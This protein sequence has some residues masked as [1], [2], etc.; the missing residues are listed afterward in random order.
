MSQ[1]SAVQTGR[2]CVKKQM[3]KLMIE[4]KDFLKIIN[5]EDFSVSD[6]SVWMILS[7]DIICFMS[8][9]EMIIY[10]DLVQ[11]FINISRC[12]KNKILLHFIIMLESYTL[13][14]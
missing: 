11:I 12:L 2:I 8:E 3:L 7:G 9:K 10:K 14:Y 6:L 1:F 5:S 13:K 4:A